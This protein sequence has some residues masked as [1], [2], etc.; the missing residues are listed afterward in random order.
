MESRKLTPLTEIDP[1]IKRRIREDLTVLLPE[2]I[3]GKQ[4]ERDKVFD[5][6]NQVICKKHLTLCFVDGSPIFHNIRNM[7]MMELVI[8]ADRFYARRLDLLSVSDY[9]TDFLDIVR[10]SE[11]AVAPMIRAID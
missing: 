5:L 7:A 11:L 9:V 4:G 3:I 8:H 1:D 10:N 6:M 2:G